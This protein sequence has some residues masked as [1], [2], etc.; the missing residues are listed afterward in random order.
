MALQDIITNLGTAIIN[1]VDR[2]ILKHCEQIE[3]V[4]LDLKTKIDILVEESGGNGGD[5]PVTPPDEP[6]P[7]LGNRVVYDETLGKDKVILTKEYL[8]KYISD[9]TFTEDLEIWI[10]EYPGA[11]DPG[12]TYFLTAGGSGD[13][14][15]GEIYTTPGS[16]YPS[17]IRYGACILYWDSQTDDL[18]MLGTSEDLNSI[19]SGIGLIKFEG[20]NTID[21]DGKNLGSKSFNIEGDIDIDEPDSSLG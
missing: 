6:T 4:L 19:D 21:K 15:S 1:L 9:I 8:N 17:T 13:K 2:K 3:T 7:E 18:D 10:S 20:I 5:T 12:S 16:F 11:P 14:P